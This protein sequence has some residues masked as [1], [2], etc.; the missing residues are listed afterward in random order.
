MVNTANDSFYK[1]CDF[2]ETSV[3]NKTSP[4][5]DSKIGLL[6]EF[7]DCWGFY[8]PGVEM[9]LV[10]PT[11]SLKAMGWVYLHEAAHWAF[12]K[13]HL[14]CDEQMCDDVAFIVQKRLGLDL[15]GLV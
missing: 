15:Y 1:I 10:N 7:I 3:R 8:V 4:T 14:T 9:I 13:H 5:R 11:C 12:D 2:V 6:I